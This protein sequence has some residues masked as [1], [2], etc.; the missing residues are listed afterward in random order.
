MR[1]RPGLL[2]TACILAFGCGRSIVYEAEPIDVELEESWR[3][4]GLPIGDGHVIFSNKTMLTVAYEDGTVTALAA[5]WVAAL[6][7][8]GW[9]PDFRATSD[10]QVTVRM[11]RDTQELALGAIPGFDGIT[12]TLTI[13]DP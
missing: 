9:T 7:R 2:I 10:V 3:P 8:L 1:I 13:T 4:L 11:F 6:R 12:V 5:V